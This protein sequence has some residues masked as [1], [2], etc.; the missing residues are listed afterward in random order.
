VRVGIHVRHWEGQPHDL[1]PLAREAERVGL[2]SVWVSET[3]GSDAIVLATWLAAATARIGIGVGVAQMAA[4]TPAA[5][6]MSAITLDHLSAGR[7]RLGMGSS[8]PQVVE[9]WHGVPFDRPLERTRE[10]LAIVRA[11]VAREAPVTFDGRYYHLPA[12]DGTGLGKPLKAN[13]RPLRTEVPLY[14]A[15]MGPRN[16]ALAAEI[17]DGWLPL[18]YAPDRAE[19]FAEPLRQGAAARDPD[20]PPLDVS[21]I[22]W[23][24]IGDDLEVCRDAVRPSIARYVGAYGSKEAN[25]YNDLVH[26]YG[27]GDEATRIQDLYL[28]GRRDE[29]VAAVSDA[30]VD[31]VALVGSLSRVADR[32]AAYR[33]A[34]VTTLLAM[35]DDV[36]AIGDLAA[37]AEKVGA[38]P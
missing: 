17:A 1:V 14:L 22:A 12:G 19:V 34:G 23:V 16:V 36:A 18:L 13:V 2:D 32:M 35:I 8:G 25:F 3:W 29:A 26:R 33:D 15:A 37:A 9:G 21:P 20:R 38:T 28:G 24:A 10:Y 30:L 31:E 27:Y 5:A 4:R 7:L 6:A 11:I